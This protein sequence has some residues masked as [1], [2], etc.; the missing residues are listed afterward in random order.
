[1]RHSPIIAAL[2]A[3][4]ACSPDLRDD[5]P[6]DGDLP[7]GDYVTFADLGGGVSELRVNAGEPAG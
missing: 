2:A 6:F 5:F 7:A 1:M 4:T 3:V